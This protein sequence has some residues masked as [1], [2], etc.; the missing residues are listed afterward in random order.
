MLRSILL[1]GRVD[2]TLKY[3]LGLIEKIQEGEWQ[4]ALSTISFIYDAKD[5]ENP[6][7]I[8]REVIKVTTNYVMNQEV[9]EL[10]EVVYIPAVLSTLRYGAAHE[11]KSTIGF[12]NQNFYVVNNPQ[13]E[14]QV[15]LKTVDTNKM[16]EGSTVFLLLLLRRV[17]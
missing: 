12:K 2:Q 9:N 7:E 13:Q 4:I 10:G 3:P 11:S 15:S 5:Q 16:T 1:K 6:K 8:P 14:L 17:R